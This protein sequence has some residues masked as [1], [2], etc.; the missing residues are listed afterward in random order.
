MIDSHCHFDFPVFDQDRDEILQRCT[1]AGVKKIVIP[2]TQACSWSKL[3]SLCDIHENLEFALGLHPYF[4]SSAGEDDLQTLSD[5]VKRHRKSIVAV[6]EIG[7][8]F[9]SAQTNA[10]QIE[11]FQQQLHIANDNNLPIVV[12]HRKSHNQL[13]R[14]LKN[15]PVSKGGVIHAFS[16]SYF[17]AKTYLDLGF[18]LGVGGTITYQ[19]ASKTREVIKQLPIESLLLETDAPDMPIFGR[20]GQRNSPEFLPEIVQALCELKSMSKDEVVDKTS[21]TSAQ[22][23]DLE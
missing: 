14:M 1:S 3:I 4:I 12:H 7:L 13:I 5:L 23:F 10:K 17:E 20:Q 11:Y 18:K 8:D 16:G 2:G 21:Q 15:T 22:L 9:A 19:R 6:G